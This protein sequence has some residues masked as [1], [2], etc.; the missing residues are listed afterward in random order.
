MRKRAL[1]SVLAVTAATVALGALSATPAL[2]DHGGGGGGGGRGGGR[3]CGSAV[4]AS[5]TGS[6]GSR[7]TLSSSYDDNDQTGGVI[8][9]EEFQVNTQVANQVWAV[10]FTYNGTTFLTA[11]VTSTTAGV[12]EAASTAYTGGTS[13]L[14]VTAVNQTTGETVTSSVTDPAAPSRCGAGGGD[15]DG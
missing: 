6:L 9:E 7:F 2:A 4:S 8:V 11:S 14:A 15:G 13:Q 5:G 12:H 3:S 1:T 10:T